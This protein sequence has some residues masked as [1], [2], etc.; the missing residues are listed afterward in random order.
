MF[1]NSDDRAGG[2]ALGILII[3]GSI[4]LASAAA[5]SERILQKATIY[6]P[7]Q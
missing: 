4:A 3:C 6:V 2:V 7:A 1:S 5:I